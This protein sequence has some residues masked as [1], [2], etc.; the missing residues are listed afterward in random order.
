MVI[1]DHLNTPTTSSEDDKVNIIEKFDSSSYQINTEL[2]SVKD[3]PTNQILGNPL[4][5]VH[6]RIQLENI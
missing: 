1:D 3:H 6:T 4:I 2:R 5:G